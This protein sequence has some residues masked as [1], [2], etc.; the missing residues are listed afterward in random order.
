[1]EPIEFIAT[2]PFSNTAPVPLLRLALK[3]SRCEAKSME[4]RVVGLIRQ[5]C[6]GGNDHRDFQRTQHTGDVSSRSSEH[7]H[8]TYDSLPV[9]FEAEFD[10]A[11]DLSPRLASR[12]SEARFGETPK[13]ARVR[14]PK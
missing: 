9:A 11:M 13:P 12:S 6:G 14:S 5:R 8:E 3:I 4:L 7:R 2:A 10:R 1:M